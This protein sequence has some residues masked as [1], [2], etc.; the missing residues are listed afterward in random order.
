MMLDSLATFSG[1]L[2]KE[3]SDSMAQNSSQIASSVW[4]GFAVFIRPLVA[5][6]GGLLGVYIIYKI[7]QGVL[8]YFQTKRIKRIDSN[9]QRLDRKVDEILSLLKKKK[10]K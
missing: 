1:N 6:L 7:V 5:V 3:I 2:T 8:N 4:E 10:S 9:V